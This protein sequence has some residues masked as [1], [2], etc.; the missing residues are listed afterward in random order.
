MALEDIIEKTLK[1]KRGYKY[2]TYQTLYDKD[3]N[4][5]SLLHYG[6]CILEVKVVPPLEELP[7]YAEV[8][9]AFVTSVSDRDSINKTIRQI[10]N[11]THCRGL[12][13][14]I[15]GPTFGGS[16][17]KT[18][19]V[20]GRVFGIP[21]E[22]E[23]EFKRMVHT[24]STSNLTKLEE[25]LAWLHPKNIGRFIKAVKNNKIDNIHRIYLAQQKAHKNY[26]E[27]RERIAE[28]LDTLEKD[29]PAL[30][31]LDNFYNHGLLQ[32]RLDDF[33]PSKILPKH[34]LLINSDGYYII[35]KRH[36]EVIRIFKIRGYYSL[37][38]FL[39]RYRDFSKVLNGDKFFLWNFWGIEKVDRTSLFADEI[40]GVVRSLATLGYLDSDTSLEKLKLWHTQRI[41]SKGGGCA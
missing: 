15:Y 13:Y 39:A 6:T 25:V 18:V 3:K 21:I 35:Q 41:L 28:V 36:R 19:E 10:E 12:G 30:L 37:T 9:D 27:R 23:E 1:K 4:I 33:T 2:H 29:L 40:E 17:I 14:A 38:S 26:L 8:L 24:L 31:P 32:Q 11:Y 5:F 22:Y 7:S 20:R 34:S 16:F